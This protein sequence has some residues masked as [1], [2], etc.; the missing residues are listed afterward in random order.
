VVAGQDKYGTAKRVEDIHDFLHQHPVYGIVFEEIT[1][2]QNEIR[3]T[4]LG[5]SYYPM[6]CG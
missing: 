2:D 1:G 6:S 5:S 3:R 4:V